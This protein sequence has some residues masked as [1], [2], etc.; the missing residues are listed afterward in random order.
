MKERTPGRWWLK[1]A[2]G[3]DPRTGRTRFKTKTVGAA[4]RKEAQRELSR[5]LVEVD[6]GRAPEAG[7]RLTVGAYLD[8]WL[9]A[10][11]LH[12]STRTLQGYEYIVEER[13]KPHLGRLSLVKLTP[14]DIEAAY[15]AL[16][17]YGAKHGGPLS[18]QSVKHVHRCLFTALDA[19]VKKERLITYN[20]ASAIRPPRVPRKEARILQGPEDAARLLGA[21]RGHKYYEPVLVALSTGLRRGEVLALRWR[22]IDLDAGRLTVNLAWEA[23]KV[24]PK[25]GSKLEEKGQKATEYRLKEPKTA[26]GR[27]TVYIPAVVVDALKAYKARQKEEM[28]QTGARQPDGLAFC[29]HFTGAPMSLNAMSGSFRQIAKD[30]GLNVT[31][32]GLRHSHISSLL[33]AGVPLK[34]VSERAGHAS[35][36]VT[37]DIYGHLLETMD[38]ATAEVADGPLREALDRAGDTR[39]DTQRKRRKSAVGKTAIRNIADF[40]VNKDK[41]G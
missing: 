26:K 14:S 19:A 15:A 36:S 31:L 40:R 9:R 16:L 1:V 39:F 33:M 6:E 2:A 8:R 4:T 41:F 25:P 28:M 38:R 7:S 23:V 3:I 35:V 11:A 18:P 32:H 30:A 24:D 29:C 34:H 10:H 21:L 37:A 22:D 12:V 27:R 13:I 20:P 17:E 5:F